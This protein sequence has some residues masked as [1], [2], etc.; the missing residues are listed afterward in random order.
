MLIMKMTPLEQQILHQEV[1]DWLDRE[2]SDPETL[3]ALPGMAENCPPGTP[4][5]FY[6]SH[7]RKL[8]EATMELEDGQEI[9]PEY[10]DSGVYYDWKDRRMIRD[11]HLDNQIL[12][13]EEREIDLESR[14][15]TLGMPLPELATLRKEIRQWK[16]LQRLR[17]D[18]TEPAD[19][20]VNREMWMLEHLLMQYG[21]E[22]QR[23]ARLKELELTEARKQGMGD[24]V[25]TAETGTETE[26]QTPVQD[27]RE[28][29]GDQPA[30]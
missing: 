4:P 18:M 20:A 5:E 12:A 17:L 13:M 26:D 8:R 28:T 19:L 3:W 15:K 25:T 21:S 27:S 14:E 6:Q 23:E 16:A 11:Q 30:E 2:T 22:P 7:L 1:V 9:D 29:L 10:L 24:L